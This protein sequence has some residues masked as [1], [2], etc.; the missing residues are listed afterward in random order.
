[1]KQTKLSE[2]L[3]VFLAGV[4]LVVPTVASAQTLPWSGGAGAGY[5]TYRFGNAESIGVESVSLFA[6]PFGARALLFRGT[7]LE[8]TGSFARGSLIK[9]DGTEATISGLTDTDIRVSVPVVGADLVTLSGI[10]ALPTG[11]TTHT[12]EEAE[13]AAIIAA[14]LL[15]FRVSQWGSGGGAGLGATVARAG[16]GG[17]VRLSASYLAARE[18]E[19]IAASSG[20]GQF[21]YRP[22]N[23]LRVQLMADRNVG[24]A[25]KAALQL[26]FM[27][28]GDDQ[29]QGIN[30][31]QAGGRYQAIGSY[32]FGVGQGSSGIVYGGALHRTNGVFVPN[33]IRE[34]QLQDQDDVA[35]QTLF[36]GGTGMRVSAGRGVLIPSVD[37]RLIRAED[38][39]NQ[40]FNAG[41]GVSAEWPAAGVTLVPT[42]RA[43]FGDWLV[44][45]GT[46]SGFTGLDLGLTLRLGAPR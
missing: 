28:S 31:Y 38:G 42:L 19:P 1:M 44:R 32:S 3:A 36:M 17:G 12:L 30:L 26:T 4:P 27:H 34:L 9:P 24:A 21:T 11:H 35:A 33:G 6:I 20:E 39:F 8:V 40:G 14:D 2:A 16:E 10:V 25:G 13:V 18:F 23:Q 5:E 29:T 43:R 37:A 15:P 46:E 45:E 41:A 22:G 7:S